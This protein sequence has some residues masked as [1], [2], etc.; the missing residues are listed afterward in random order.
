MIKASL[1]MWVVRELR[2]KRLCGAASPE[3]NGRGV[4]VYV[5]ARVCVCVG[6]GWLA[7]AGLRCGAESQWES[8]QCK[9]LQDTEERENSS[10]RP[11]DQ[12]ASSA[13]QQRR[14]R[15]HITTPVS[16]TQHLNRDYYEETLNIPEIFSFRQVEMSVSFLQ[17]EV[18][19]TLIFGP[20]FE[21]CF[22]HSNS[23]E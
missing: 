16:T 18:K 9:S 6:W 1:S 12:P 10:C 21:C 17:V 19:H 13:G 14:C 8:G 23:F 2:E 3:R 4:C 7:V 11:T 5:C 20:V 15:A 22:A